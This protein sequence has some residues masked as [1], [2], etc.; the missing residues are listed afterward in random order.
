[1]GDS[2]SYLDD[3]LVPLKM[4]R[5][6]SSHSRS[7]SSTFKAIEQRKVSVS[8]CAYWR[9]SVCSERDGISLLTSRF[10]CVKRKRKNGKKHI[11][12]DGVPL[13]NESRSRDSYK[14]R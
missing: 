12:F 11:S 3:L 9:M 14:T 7:V 8:K 5:L 10:E 13:S 4:F 2:L 1:M 6:K